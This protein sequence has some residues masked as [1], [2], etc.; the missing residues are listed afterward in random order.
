MSKKCN[1]FGEISKADN[2]LKKGLLKTSLFIP[3]LQALEFVGD[4]TVHEILRFVRLDH[5]QIEVVRFQ[6][7]IPKKKI[8]EFLV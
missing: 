6:H 8:W 2:K 1:I 5:D 3:V 7:R 4:E